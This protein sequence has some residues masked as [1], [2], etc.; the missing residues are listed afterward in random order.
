MQSCVVNMPSVEIYEYEHVQVM[1]TQN[2]R[3]NQMRWT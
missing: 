2:V 1:M 3:P